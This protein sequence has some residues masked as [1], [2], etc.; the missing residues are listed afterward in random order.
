M[1]TDEISSLT[2]YGPLGIMLIVFVYLHWQGLRDSKERE[3]QLRADLADNRDECKADTA[4]L[5]TRIQTLE[6][7]HREQAFL[8]Q[9]ATL[10]SLKGYAT[11]LTR[12]LDA[13]TD[14]MPAIRHPYPR[15]DV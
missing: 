14:R 10:E 1:P 9:Q 11:A 7:Q 13:E 8:V 2:T 15:S 6:D 5:V 12:F 3:I 4:K